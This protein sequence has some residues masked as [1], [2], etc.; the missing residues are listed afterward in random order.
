MAKVLVIEDD[1]N[2]CKMLSSFLRERDH[3]PTCVLTLSEGLENA[4]NGAFDV[5]FLDVKLPD[6]N[7]LD[8]I[9]KIKAAP[10]LPEVIIITGHAGPQGAELAIRSGAWDYFKKGTSL[11]DISLALARALQYREKEKAAASGTSFKRDEILGDSQRLRMCLN[12]AA[13]A[14]GQDAN[15]L[16]TGETGTG[17]ELFA[18]AIHANSSRAR[19]GFVVVDCAAIP[20][21]L[22]ESQL[23]GHEKGAFTGADSSRVGL[24]RQADGGTLLLDE[25]GELPLSIQRSFLRVLQERRFRPVG[26]DKEMSSDFRLIAATNRDLDEM[27][28]LG[29]FRNDL[30]FRLRTFIIELPPLKKRKTDIPEVARIYV[31]QICSRYNVETLKCSPEFLEGLIEYDWPGNVRELVHSLEQ[32]ISKASGEKVLYRDHLP[33]Q[34]RVHLAGRTGQVST[35]TSEQEP[36][37][38]KT[39][40]CSLREARDAAEKTYLKQLLAKTKGNVKE[41]CRIAGLSRSRLYVLLQ[42]HDLSV[43]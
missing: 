8:A 17:K 42:K 12:L 37:L 25:V 3:D 4:E 14:A 21:T 1:A 27:V 28:A 15:V 39:T 6:G 24:I 2:M 35:G 19:E 26:S 41:T 30:L 36:D 29:Q 5:V 43:K 38:V 7:G 34:I 10:S 31:N 33:T 16:L 40:L 20:G 13:Q 9:P 18:R 23:F 22:V 11:S 32:S